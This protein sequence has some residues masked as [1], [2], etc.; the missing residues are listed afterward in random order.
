MALH[1]ESSMQFS[2]LL[3]SST[4]VVSDFYADWCGPCKAIAPTYE[5]LATKH[6][7]PNRVTFTKINV[8]HQQSIAQRY[9]VRAMPTFLIFQSGSVIE[10]IQGADVRKLT[11]AI[12]NAVKLSGA[13][14]PAYSSVGRTL[15]G[16]SPTSSSVA[17]SFSF[18]RLFHGIISFFGLY[19]YSLFSFDA[20]TSA[21][22]SPFN[23]HRVPA[24]P[25]AK[26]TGGRPGAS[27][28]VGKK[29]GTI[30]DLAGKD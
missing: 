2:K 16:S 13:A 23:I 11:T 18:D 3:G 25:A 1:I 9:G 15:G 26:T 7:K 8:D 6:S 14:K 12:E 29:L 22:N 19:L 10:T 4:I 20:Y 17:R 30:A 27:T 24:A 28:Q 5:S 21:E